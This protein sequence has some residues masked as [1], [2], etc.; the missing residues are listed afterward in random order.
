[1]LPLLGGYYYL[2]RCIRTKFRYKRLERQ[3]LIFDSSIYGFG[4]LLVSFVLWLLITWR[5]PSLELWLV[6]I[7]LQ[8]DFFYPSLFSFLLAYGWTNAFNTL[9]R[10]MTPNVENLYLSKAIEKT[11]NSMQLDLLKSYAT[12]QLL[13]ITLRNG[14]VYVGIATELNEPDG[15]SYIRI[16]PFYSGY[17]TESLDVQLT[18]DYLS[19]YESIREAGS[20]EDVNTEMVICEEDIITTTFYEQEIFNRFN[21]TGD[22]ENSNA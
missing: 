12:Q 14:K 13:M 20:Q 3:R 10:K 11:G 6:K 7:P 17:R 4:F 16:L 18:T 5:F 19:V 1:M 21:D 8:I 9:K 2:T 15:Q 22:G